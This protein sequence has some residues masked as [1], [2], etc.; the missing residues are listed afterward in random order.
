MVFDPQGLLVE[1]FGVNLRNRMARGLM[2]DGDFA[3]PAVL[4]LWWLVL[5]N[6]MIYA[7]LNRNP[8]REEAGEKG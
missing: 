8:K 3:S 7:L 6:C 5:R 4:Y 2:G 1:R